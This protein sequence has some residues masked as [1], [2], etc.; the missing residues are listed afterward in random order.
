[1]GVDQPKQLDKSAFT[2]SKLN[3]VG[4]SICGEWSWLWAILEK[5]LWVL[6]LGKQ[7]R[8][9]M[10]VQRQKA[11]GGFTDSQHSPLSNWKAPSGKHWGFSKRTLKISLKGKSSIK[12]ANA[13]EVQVLL[14]LRYFMNMGQRDSGYG[15]C[16]RQGAL[17]LLSRNKGVKD[18]ALPKPASDVCIWS[19]PGDCFLFPKFL[20]WWLRFSYH[21]VTFPGR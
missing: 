1:M 3:L 5:T 7:K 6:L 14:I 16:Q 21:L 20:F 2:R 4:Q 18:E 15:G 13:L 17:E 10:Y 19:T 9:E 11:E 12:E 8:Q